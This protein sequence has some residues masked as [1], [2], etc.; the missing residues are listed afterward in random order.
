MYNIREIQIV[1]RDL[2]K[3][4]LELRKYKHM[5][6]RKINRRKL[7]LNEIKT[8]SLV[9]LCGLMFATFV[10]CSIPA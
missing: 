7:I 5:Y 6:F 9:I 3:E 10:I 8:V 4:N 1:D 2:M